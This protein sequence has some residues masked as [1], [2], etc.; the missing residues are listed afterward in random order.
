MIVVLKDEVLYR[1]RFLNFLGAVVSFKTSTIGVVENEDFRVCV[2]LLNNSDILQRIVPI[3]LEFGNALV[4]CIPIYSYS[5][6]K[7]N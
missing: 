2:E 5:L 7:W 1:L 6:S 4:L 3:I